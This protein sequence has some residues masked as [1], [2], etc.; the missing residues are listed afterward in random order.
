[1]SMYSFCEINPLSL[2]FNSHV[3]TGFKG[4]M[5]ISLHAWDTESILPYCSR[6]LCPASL[7]RAV[8][9]LGKDPSFRLYF[10]RASPE[11]H[12][13]TDSFSRGLEIWSPKKASRWMNKESQNQVSPDTH[14]LH[15]LACVRHTMSFPRITMWMLWNYTPALLFCAC[16]STK[17]TRLRRPCLP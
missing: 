11:I 14:R 1:M 16:I 15:I 17:L 12:K 9:P 8:S 6:L 4:I 5:G 3:R 2:E 10:L 7:L 13:H